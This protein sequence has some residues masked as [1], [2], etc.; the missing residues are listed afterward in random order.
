ML[1]LFLTRK[2]KHIEVGKE[3][4]TVTKLINETERKLT[5]CVFFSKL[6]EETHA[7]KQ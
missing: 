1:L 7:I 2:R 4:S 5:F 3:G 6:F